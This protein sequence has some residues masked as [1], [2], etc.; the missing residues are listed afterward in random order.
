MEKQGGDSVFS[1]IIQNRKTMDS[2][3]LHYPLFLESLDRGEFSVCRWNEA[4]TTIDTATPELAELVNDKKEWRAIIVHIEDEASMADFARNERNPFD[5]E[6]NGENL[7]AVQESP[8]PLIR[9][10]HILGGVPTPIKRFVERI[11]HDSVPPH[12]VYE[13]VDDSEERVQH[14]ILSEKY[15]YDGKRPTEIILVTLRG[16]HDN[17]ENRSKRAWQNTIENTS[18]DFWKRN[19]YPSVCRFLVFDT[20]R[21]GSVERTAEMF[22]FWTSVMI[23]ARNDVDPDFLQAY[24]LYRLSTAIDLDALHGSIQ[25]TVNRLAG[26]QVTIQES[27]R[28]ETQKRLNEA[29]KLPDCT[30]EVPVTFDFTNK[31]VK[32]TKAKQFGLASKSVNAELHR[33]GELRS[34]S[35]QEVKAA[36][37]VTD[38]ALEQSAERLHSTSECSDM[39]VR[40]LDKYEVLDFEQRLEEMYNEIAELL[41]ELPREPLYSE[42]DVAEAANKVN[43]A[44][45]SRVTVPQAF[46][47]VGI[48]AGLLGLSFVTA[49]VYLDSQPNGSAWTLAC[50]ALI[51]IALLSAIAAV[52]LQFKRLRLAR[53]IS[54]Y[55]GKLK[56]ILASLTASAQDFSRYMS[57]IASHIRGSVFLELFRRKNFSEEKL[58]EARKT[59]MRETGALIAK[60]RMW[61]VA[62][63]IPVN[64]E[65]DAIEDNVAVDPLCPPGKNPLYT[66]ESGMRYVVPLNI[67]GDN[68]E[69]PFEFVTQLR[70]NREELYNDE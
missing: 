68:V 21:Q 52:V 55:T 3:N 45:L 38:R 64:F 7:C 5:F 47:A 46:A 8:V 48:V 27:I 51:G 34:A 59:H 39:A 25:R 22:R 35:E 31:Q 13:P 16:K 41:E 11:I 53:E 14:R 70:I 12:V 40:R 6:A 60:L 44:I 29:S 33:W 69:S 20:T 67:S 18:S 42:K 15:Q 49:A 65:E 36:F 56:R 62:F 24:R 63:H 10:T 30:V 61:S 43:E 58:L 9:L 17:S 50:S 32:R 66:F 19:S 57:K 37:H 28:I 2:F 4:G 54:N 23:V 26:A 1:V